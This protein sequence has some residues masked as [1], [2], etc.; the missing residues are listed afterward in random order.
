MSE[1]NTLTVTL[2]SEFPILNILLSAV[3]IEVKKINKVIFKN[4]FISF[5]EYL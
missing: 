3:T 5:I 1:E 2:A 4:L